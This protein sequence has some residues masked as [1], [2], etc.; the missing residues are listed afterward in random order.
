LRFAFSFEGSFL[1][2][3]ILQNLFFE[4]WIKRH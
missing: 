2:N 4:N 3:E 1:M